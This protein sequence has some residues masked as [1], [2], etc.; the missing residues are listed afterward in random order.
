MQWPPPVA[1]L[2]ET[3]A[4]PQEPQINFARE[5]E[6]ATERFPA[7]TCAEAVA[8]W[9]SLRAPPEVLE[10]FHLRVSQRKRAFDAE[11]QRRSREQNPDGCF[12]NPCW[13]GPAPE[14]WVEQQTLWQSGA[15]KRSR[16]AEALAEHLRKNKKDHLEKELDG[17]IKRGELVIGAFKFKD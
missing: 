12:E 13:P 8:Q 14:K 6:K 4:Y 17:L 15:Q 2:P 1:A 7:F 11:T 16:T 3:Q 10:G 5:R 9:K